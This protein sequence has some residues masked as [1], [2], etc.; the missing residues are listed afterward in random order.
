MKNGRFMFK[1]F[2][3]LLL[4]TITSFIIKVGALIMWSAIQTTH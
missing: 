2:G 4:T 3:A 1:A